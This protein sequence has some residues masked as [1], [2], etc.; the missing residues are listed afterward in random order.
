MIKLIITDL[1]KT[2]LNDKKEVTDY[3]AEVLKKCQTKGIKVA[4]ATARPERATMNFQQSF[5]PDYIISNNGA[6]IS[7]KGKTIYNNFIPT[8]I[9]NMLIST[10]I[11]MNDVVCLTVE[12]GTCLY[13][14]YNG[15]PW[16][17]ENWNPIYNDFS[18]PLKISIPKVSIECKNIDPIT[19]LVAKY[20]NLHLYFNSGE[21]WSQVMHIDSTKMRAIH[22]LSK[23]LG[24]KDQNIVAFGDD[25]NDIEM[26]QQC[27]K[28]IAV[29]NGIESVKQVADCI[30]RS[31]NDDGVA[32]W[33]ETN[34]FNS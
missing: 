26:L 20:P 11:A 34:L 4:F 31:N 24:I 27:G 28:G 3:T 15:E 18:K 7:C 32:K 29:E 13:T 9:G 1:D 25:F 10:L 8:D 6:T 33:I 2:L 12:A 16:D 14:N 19:E 30:C 23:G 21:N 5:Q 17:T 22:Y